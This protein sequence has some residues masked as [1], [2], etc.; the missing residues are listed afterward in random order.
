MI[1][2][3][4]LIGLDIWIA[5]KHCWWWKCLFGNQCKSLYYR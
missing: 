2:I 4:T 3:F 1:Y 5:F